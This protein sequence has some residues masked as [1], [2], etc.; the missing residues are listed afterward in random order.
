[1]CV[2]IPESYNLVLPGL[3]PYI[4]TV[5]FVQHYVNEHCDLSMCPGSSHVGLIFTGVVLEMRLSGGACWVKAA[6]P[7]RVL[8]PP[9]WEQ[10]CYHGNLPPFSSST[11]AFLL[12]CFLP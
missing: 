2:F 3:N 11:C 9:L 12:F 6:E 5:F 10:A 1:M 8:I 4:Y 7:H